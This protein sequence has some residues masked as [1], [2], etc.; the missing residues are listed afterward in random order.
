MSRSSPTWSPRS[1]PAP[2]A[3]PRTRAP[4]WPSFAS[5]SRSTR[6]I[7]DG[8]E[9][10]RLTYLGACAGAPAARRHAGGRHRRRL[11]RAGRRLGAG[12]RLLRL[13]PGRHRSP[14]RAPPEDR[15]A[16]GRRPRGARRRR[17]RADRRRARRHGRLVNAKQGIAV[18]GTPTSL[19]AI[20]QE[21]DPYD[22]ERVHGFELSLDSIQRMCSMLASMTLEE[23][24]AGHRPP[25][26]PGA[27]DRRRG[28]D[29]DP[30]DARLRASRDRGLRARHPL[31]RGAPGGRARRLT[32]AQ[33]SSASA[34]NPGL[35]PS[36][37]SDP[38]RGAACRGARRGPRRRGR[39]RSRP[40]FALGFGSALRGRGVDVQHDASLV[41]LVHLVASKNRCPP[42]ID[43]C[44]DHDA[45]EHVHVR[46]GEHVLR[47]FPLAAVARVDTRRPPRGSCRSRVRRGPPRYAGSWV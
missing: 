40:G 3:T 15:P 25:P 42:G 6:S 2:S 18:A 36:P 21:L 5:A 28:R 30:G 29:P 46:I 14:H 16:R 47:P 34:E 10:A 45:V 8:A 44:V 32:S 22:P 31:R 43:A 13:A 26:R 38:R 33:N 12:G 19:A 9:E 35:S 7:L 27:D 23:R 41:Y 4:S 20:E 39:P 24:L 37:R 11:D 17:P 1:P